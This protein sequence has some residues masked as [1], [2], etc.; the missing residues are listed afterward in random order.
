MF[1]QN[2]HTTFPRVSL[3]EITTEGHIPKYFVQAC[4]KI[5]GGSSS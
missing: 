5:E 3:F 1:Y 2:F 4:L